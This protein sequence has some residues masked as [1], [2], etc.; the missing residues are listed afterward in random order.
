MHVPFVLAS[1]FWQEGMN[2]PEEPLLR[3]DAKLSPD[4][5]EEQDL[6]VLLHK[7]SAQPETTCKL[8]DIITGM[9]VPDISVKIPSY[10][11]WERLL[12]HVD[13]PFGLLPLLQRGRSAF[14]NAP[15]APFSDSFIILELVEPFDEFTHVVFLLQSKRKETAKKRNEKDSELFW[16]FEKTVF[17]HLA[18]YKASHILPVYLYITDATLFGTGILLTLSLPP[19]K[20]QT[21]IS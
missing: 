21:L 14:V 3:L 13:S 10:L 18:A 19:P 7:L 15:H 1:S 17:R 4:D 9:P 2:I 16:D 20:K 11:S 6:A 5:N 12:S 8:A